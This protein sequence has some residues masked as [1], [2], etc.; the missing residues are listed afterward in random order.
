MAVYVFQLDGAE[1]KPDAVL[2]SSSGIVLCSRMQTSIVANNR[3]RRVL[4]RWVVR[5]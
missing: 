3:K 1:G 4:G 5:W 2:W